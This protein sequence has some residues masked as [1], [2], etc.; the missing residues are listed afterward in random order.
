[1]CCGSA[2]TG[3]THSVIHREPNR[4]REDLP[5]VR[6]TYVGRSALTV[7]GSA[8]QTLYR[9]G[10]PGATMAVDRRDAYS[11]AAVPTLRHAIDEG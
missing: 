3:P 10:E 2:R 4:F 5:Y 8:T 11:L 1:M 6:F 9:F 7:I